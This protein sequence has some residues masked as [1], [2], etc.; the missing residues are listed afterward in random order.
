MHVLI[1]WALA[2]GFTDMRAHASIDFVNISGDVEKHY[3]VSSLG[4]GA[5]FIDYDGDADLDLYLVN[6]QRIGSTESPGN[7]LYRNE[8]EWRFLD[9]SER[10]GASDVGWSIGC[11][12]GDYDND[13]A[14]DLY[15]TN[16][17]ANVLYRNRG[18]GTFEARPSEKKGFGTSA[19]F[20]DA[21]ADGDLD[22]YV[23]SYVDPDL[24]KLAAPG[25]DPTCVWLGMPVM[26]GPKGLDGQADVF[27]RNESGRFVDATDNA[28]L[29]DRS[30]AFGLGVVSGDYD[31]DGDIDLYVANDTHP[32]FLYQN[33]GSG[34]FREVG[35]L[36]G[37]A[38]N[39]SGSTEAGMGV[40]FGDV[41]ADGRPDL[42]VTNFSHETNT[43][44]MGSDVGMFTDE[45][46]ERGLGTTSLGW[47]GWGA[48]FADFDNDG[49]E[50]LFVANGHVYPNV[51]SADDSTTY[52]QK[53][54]IFEND[55]TGNFG[56]ALLLDEEASSRGA[57]FGDIDDDGDI[58]AVVIN[59]ESQPSIL[60]NDAESAEHFLGVVLVGTVSN[61]DGYGARVSITS[62]EHTQVKLAGSDGSIFSANDGR[63]HFG[64]GEVDS[65]EELRVEWPS[66]TTTVLTD[67]LAGAYLLV[68]EGE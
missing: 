23:A 27:Y 19:A 38:Y 11:A 35:L 55:G 22:L 14:S 20:F 58:D 47:L 49:D 15:V 36:S 34:K 64:L 32:N 8:G 18:D 53:N 4:G 65:L 6:G 13:G 59:I 67:V 45:S 7:R 10:S 62:G 43:L 68:V 33:D 51:E 37:A 63:V 1:V 17:G 2:V 39:L 42:F 29:T 28:G 48:G 57:A 41:D 52:L 60:R 54:Q 30:L 26:C 25:T 44:Y 21:D 40:D 66:G 56:D 3:I 31:L 46:E 61:R 24:S 16:I 9:V 12:V 50:D 5:C